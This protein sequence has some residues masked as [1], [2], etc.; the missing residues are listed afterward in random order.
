MGMSVGV[1]IWRSFR[2]QCKLKRRCQMRTKRLQGMLEMVFVIMFATIYVCCWGNS[3][4]WDDG[5]LEGWQGETQ[6]GKAGHQGV[7]EG[8]KCWNWNLRVFYSYKGTREHLTEEK[9]I[10]FG[11]CP[12]RMGGGPSPIFLLFFSHYVVPYILTSISCYV[13]LFG[14]F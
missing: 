12:K 3:G 14:H 13:I 1:L 5:G 2:R 11:H 8:W 6:G 4:H 10:S 7:E 9:S